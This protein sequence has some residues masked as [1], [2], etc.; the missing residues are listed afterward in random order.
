MS[1]QLVDN[2][3]IRWYVVILEVTS[4]D[5]DARNILKVKQLLKL[6]LPPLG[7]A[8]KVQ[9]LWQKNVPKLGDGEMG[10]WGDGILSPSPKAL[11]EG[12]DVAPEESEALDTDLAKHSNMSDVT[13]HD[14]WHFRVFRSIV[15][16]L[17]ETAGGFRRMSTAC[18]DTTHAS[19]SSRSHLPGTEAKEPEVGPADELHLRAQHEGKCLRF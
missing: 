1:Q 3:V 10:R 17:G 15:L 4:G 19:S 13:P 5:L 14:T 8:R 18:E 6:P 9:E 2:W 11:N 12:T 16:S 7:L